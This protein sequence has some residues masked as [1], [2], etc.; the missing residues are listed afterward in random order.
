MAKRMYHAYQPK[1]LRE[2]EV[3][4]TYETPKFGILWMWWK[5]YFISSIMCTYQNFYDQQVKAR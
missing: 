2:I 5:C 1:E 3:D 4:I